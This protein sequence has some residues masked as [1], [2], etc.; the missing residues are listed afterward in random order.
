M[1]YKHDYDKAMRRIY[2]IFQRAYDGETINMKEL[3]I[4]FGVSEKTIQ[5]DIDDIRSYISNENYGDY[6]EIKYNKKDKAGLSGIRPKHRFAGPVPEAS[7]LPQEIPID[8]R[9]HLL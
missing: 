9:R 6:E 4:E 3:A 2:E 5:R 1:P 8:K 7:S